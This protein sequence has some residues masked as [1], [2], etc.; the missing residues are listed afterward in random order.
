M[1]AH[2]A[3]ASPCSFARPASC[4]HVAPCQQRAMTHSCAHVAQSHAA[5]SQPD[6]RQLARMAQIGISDDEIKD[7]LPKIGSILTWFDQLQTVDVGDAPPAIHA[8]Q[9]GVQLRADDAVADAHRDTLLAMAPALENSYVRVPKTVI[10]AD[11]EGAVAAASVAASVLASSE[12]AAAPASAP[13]ASPPAAPAAVPTAPGPSGQPVPAADFDALLNLDLR[14]GR[15]THCEKH[16]EAD[17]LYVEKIDIGEAEPRTIVSGLVKFVSVE[18]MQGRLVV[19]VA[20]LKP[21]NMRGVKSAGMVLCAS[22]ADHTRVIP[23]TPPAGVEVGER[24]WFG[25]KKEQP[26]PSPPNAVEKKKM[27]EAA[28]GGLRTDAAGGAAWHGSPMMCSVGQVQAGSAYS[29]CKIT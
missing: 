17:S 20:N 19:I 13:S 18:E 2:K 11:A 21:R 28:A 10:G 5:A 23:I 25:D 16:P 29:D 26:T 24:V 4:L 22:D 8:S 1:L 27:W 6:I 14:V 15:I 9:L 12:V 3:T 7:F